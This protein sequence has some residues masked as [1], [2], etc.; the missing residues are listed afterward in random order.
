[1][2]SM[3]S[4]SVGCV[5]RWLRATL[6]GCLVSAGTTYAIPVPPAAVPV[7]CQKDH[8]FPRW[9][10]GV[11]AEAL[12][13]G[14]SRPV[15]ARLLAGIA[16]AKDI[17]AWDHRQGVFSQTFLE[18]AGR[19]VSGA[20][21]QTGRR[22]LVRHAALFQRIEQEFAVPPPV[23]VAFWGLET[24]F[25]QITGKFATIRSLATLA[26]DCR[27]PHV[28]RPELLAALELVERGDL[29]PSDLRG[30]W[31]GELGHFQFLP[32]YYLAHAVDYD[33]DGHRNLVRSLPDAL[34]SAANYLKW[35]GWQ[36]DQPWIEEVRVPAT[37]R[38]DRADHAITYPRRKW[39]K[40]GVV[41]ANG[42]PLPSD[43][44]PAALVL[45]MGHLG[46]AFLAYDNFRRVYLKWNESL[47]YALTAA[48]NATR[49]AGAPPVSSGAGTVVPFG[50]AD[51]MELQT[52]LRARGFDVGAADGKLGAGTR[53]AVKAAQRRLALPRDGYPTPELVA[54]LRHSIASK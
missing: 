10:A 52:L 14:V 32:S 45:P 48:Y 23:L 39:S 15:A 35:L 22:L 20:R 46:P 19:M 17:V 12:D 13:R 33:G 36:R 2:A 44:T 53:K 24:D 30:A 54:K 1:M 38:W 43:A 51:L 3:N 47:V 6:L 29:A 5:S 4:D 26:Y 11:E 7:P 27:R 18:F 42:A 28:F 41:H 34:A 21:L 9:L 8:A 40:A 16:Y 25:G 31:A 50:Y 49:L 37:L